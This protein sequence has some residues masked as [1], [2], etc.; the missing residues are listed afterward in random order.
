MGPQDSV[1]TFFYDCPHDV[2]IYRFNRFTKTAEAVCFVRTDEDS[3]VFSFQEVH[4]RQESGFLADEAPEL[5]RAFAEVKNAILGAL[6]VPKKGTRRR[7]IRLMGRLRIREAL[8][9]LLLILRDAES[10]DE[11]AQAASALGLLG[12][13]EVGDALLEAVQKWPDKSHRAEAIDALGLLD[14]EKYVDTLVKIFED[15]D[16]LLC[17]SA[18]DAL[19][20]IDGS[21]LAPI[22]I[23]QWQSADWSIRGR[24]QA[25]ELLVRLL[26]TTTDG[27]TKTYE[28]CIRRTIISVIIRIATNT[29]SV[30]NTSGLS[31]NTSF[32]ALKTPR[33]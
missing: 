21:R 19:W 2:A 11:R 15:K 10:P 12:L 29:N 23:E 20:Q 1:E 28:D 18:S 24:L 26:D 16:G 25:A 14:V 3:F 13:P 6:Q 9:P 31:M 32:P 4:E 27:H 22:L 17:R 33:L 5:A 7:M 30:I 8:S